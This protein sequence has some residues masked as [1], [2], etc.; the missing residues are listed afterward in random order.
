MAAENFQRQAGVPVETS[1][2][3][4]QE[5]LQTPASDPR[6]TVRSAES[7]R[8]MVPLYEGDRD[9]CQMKTRTHPT[10]VLAPHHR[11]T[12]HPRADERQ[13]EHAVPPISM[14]T[15]SEE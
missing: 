2:H 5:E 15:Y 13:M 11:P 1:Q 10:C 14:M 6:V 12:H 3:A 8:T 7:R 4:L 9:R